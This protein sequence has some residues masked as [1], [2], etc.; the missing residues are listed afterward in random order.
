MQTTVSEG[1]LVGGVM[2]TAE[3]TLTRLQDA[4]RGDRTLLKAEYADAPEDGLPL[5][6]YCY[7]LCEAMYHM[8]PGMFVPCRINWGGGDTHWFLRYRANTA[9]VLDCIA[10]RGQQVCTP[11][12]YAMGRRMAG[13]LTPLPSKRCRKLL[14]KAGMQFPMASVPVDVIGTL[15]L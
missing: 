2:L 15:G 10:D 5:N 8:L 11:A 6:G 13:F 7:I 4:C 3:Q 1:A 12:E 14:A 9:R